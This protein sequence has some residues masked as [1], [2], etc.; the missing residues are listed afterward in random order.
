M[1]HIVVCE[2]S[3]DVVDDI[4]LKSPPRPQGFICTPWPDGSA[5]D[6]ERARVMARQGKVRSAF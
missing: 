3:H 6:V 4:Q 2:Q 5:T 1:F